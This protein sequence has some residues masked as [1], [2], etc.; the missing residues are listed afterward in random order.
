MG[1]AAASTDERNLERALLQLGC[2]VRTGIYLSGPEKTGQGVKHTN[3][4]VLLYGR[5]RVP[6]LTVGGTNVVPQKHS[7]LHCRCSGDL[8][9]RNA[10]AGSHSTESVDILDINKG[11][12]YEHLRSPAATEQGCE[13]DRRQRD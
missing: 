9:K 7:A 11:L 6:R 2:D 1:E 12:N 4:G 8:G 10:L 5:D 3:N 13:R